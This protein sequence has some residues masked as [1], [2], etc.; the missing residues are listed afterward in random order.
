MPA[1]ARRLFSPPVL[2]AVLLA[3]RFVLLI[4]APH[5]DP[6]EARYAEIA[7]KMVETGDWITPQFDYGVPFWAKPPLSTW[8]SALGIELFG[9]NEFGSR[10]FIFI[11]ALGVLALVADAA[12]REFGKGAGWTAAAV[13]TGMPLFFYCSAAVMTDLALLMGTTL[14]MVCFR[15]ATRGGPRWRGYGVFVGLAIGLLAKGPLVLV[16]ALPPIVGW[17]VLTGRWRATREALPWVTGTILMLALALPWYVAAE[18]KTPGFLNYFLIGEHWMRFTVRG[19]Q[20]DLYGNAHPVMPGTIWI[21]LLLG[22]FPWCLGLLRARPA[23][24]RASRRWAMA[25]NGRGLYWLLWMIWPV[26]FF[27]PARNIIATYPLPALPAL[28]ILL[29]GMHAQRRNAV[30]KEEDTPPFAPVS[31]SITLAIVGTVMVMSIFFPEFSPKRSERTL[32]RRF[33]KEREPGDR[34]IYYGPRKYSAEFYTEGGIDHTTSAEN[35]AKHLDTP[36]R[37]FVALPSYWMPLVPPRVR[38]RLVPVASWGPGPSLYVE[39]T[40]LPDMAGI[41]PSRTSPIGN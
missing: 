6:S 22:A 41:D 23:G 10:I 19:W 39:R 12:R 17:I 32:I 28:A 26:A 24:W 16:I 34:L 40:D 20:G 5:T 3:C 29:A 36:G 8:M 13:L 38:R 7:R 15:S 4:V 18:Q 33:E 27:T 31:A 2:L 21:F 9:V 25:H 30:A 1:F 37:T 14:T 11:G 35:I